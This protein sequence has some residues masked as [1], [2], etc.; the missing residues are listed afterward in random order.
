MNGET[1][2]I[3]GA[4][5]GIGW[6]LARQFATDCSSLI[7]VARSHDRLE[8]LAV[9]LRQQHGCQTR[10]LTADLADPGA[11]QAICEELQRDGIQ[12]DVLVN[13]AGFG[14]AGRFDQLELDRQ[15][16]MLQVNLASLTHLTH[17]L[18]PGMIERRTGGVLNV[19]S[20]AAFQPGPMMTVYAATKAY[21]LSFTEALAE[22]LAGTGVRATCLCPGLTATAFVATAGLEKA[23]LLRFG[24]MDARKVALAGHRAFRAGK[25]LVVPGLLN[26]F[27]VFS[28]RLAPRFI[29]RKIAKRLMTPG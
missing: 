10:V 29:V 2:L 12:V 14:A 5:S 26:K 1:V 23:Q 15:L 18:L 22:E 28:V 16:G 21:V 8:R 17:R 27:T 24:A 20:T 19:A 9:V 11:P 3:T 6:E 25:L 4:S 7:L 13:N